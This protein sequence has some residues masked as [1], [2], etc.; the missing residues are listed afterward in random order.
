[1]SRK[2]VLIGAVLAAAIASDD[3]KT[4][5]N[6]AFKADPTNLGPDGTKKMM[7]DG[8]ANVGKLFGK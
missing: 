8:L 7:V 3:V 6:N 1:M 5:I 2:T 4:A